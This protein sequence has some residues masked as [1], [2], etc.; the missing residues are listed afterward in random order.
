M[1]KSIHLLHRGH[2]SILSLAEAGIG[3]YRIDPRMDCTVSMM[4]D[5]PYDL[6]FRGISFIN[7]RNEIVST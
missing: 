4:V 2:C 1:Q 3:K 7:D 5:H 6:K